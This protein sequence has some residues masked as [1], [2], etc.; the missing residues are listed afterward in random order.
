MWKVLCVKNCPLKL[1]ISSH[2]SLL[3]PPQLWPS[4]SVPPVSSQLCSYGTQ[5]RSLNQFP[6]FTYLLLQPLNCSNPSHLF[7][8][9]LLLIK[10]LLRH[11]FNILLTLE[12]EKFCSTNKLVY[13]RNHSL[14]CKLLRYWEEKQC[15]HSTAAIAG[16]FSGSNEGESVWKNVYIEFRERF[17][18]T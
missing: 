13:W 7:W 12:F 9:L 17:P 10:E 4:S 8:P 18:Q 3:T 6:R 5:G 11:N 15:S 14:L 2:L 1:K 16:C